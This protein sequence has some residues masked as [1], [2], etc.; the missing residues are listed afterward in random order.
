MRRATYQIGIVATLAVAA[1]VAC[2]HAAPQKPVEMVPIPSASAAASNTLPS[3]TPVPADPGAL[4]EKENREIRKTLKIVAAVRGLQPKSEIPGKVLSRSALIARVKDHV[5]AEVPAAAMTN[6]GLS[7]QLLGL[8]PAAGFD[9]VAESF[10]LLEAQL[11]GFYEPTDGS[12]YMASDMDEEMSFATLSH[13]LVHGLQD[14]YWDLKTRSKWAAGRSD[15]LLAQSCLAEGDATSAMLD[16]MIK[17]S[18]HTAADVPDSLLTPDMFLNADTTSVNTPH[19]MRASLIAPY[20][21]GLRFVHARRRATGGGFDGVNQAWD[22]TPTTTEQILHPDKWAA[23]EPALMV[24]S[25]PFASLGKDFALV[26]QDTFGELAVKLVFSEWMG[27]TKAPTFAA[28]WGGDRTAL[29]RKGDT[30]AL[31]WLVRY[32]EAK[33]DPK[34]NRYASDAWLALAPAFALHFPPTVKE[35][36]FVCVARRDAGPLAIATKG[37]DILFLGGPTTVT[38]GAL[39]SAGDCALAKKWA[40]EILK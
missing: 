17:D 38:A 33:G 1:F 37:R 15:S 24:A 4:D 6:E 27:E 40:N 12:M 5:V 16:V 34:P 14:Q 10:R 32:D 28:N 35:A 2:H 22:R 26:D 20:V 9:Y 21:E 25:P 31:A 29:V 3:I 23:G 7:Y 19:F 30:T 13:E 39:T 36:S 18:G 8:L 11:A